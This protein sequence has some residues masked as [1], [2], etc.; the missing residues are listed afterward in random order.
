MPNWGLSLVDAMR[1]VDVPQDAKEGAVVFGYLPSTTV[2][3]VTGGFVGLVDYMAMEAL[4]H[5]G[6]EDALYAPVKGGLYGRNLTQ[7]CRYLKDHPDSLRLTG[8][9]RAAGPQWILDSG[10]PRDVVQPERWISL[11]IAPAWLVESPGR[12]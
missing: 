4:D 11:S 12:G 9:N 5:V 2:A 10:C 6:I 7:V 3:G 1:E 8:P